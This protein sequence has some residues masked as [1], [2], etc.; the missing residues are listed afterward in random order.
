MSSF[1]D[2]KISTPLRNALDDLGLENP[3]P[4]Q[5][6]AFPVVMS[7]KDVVGIAQTGTGKTFAYLLPILNSLPFSKEKHPRVLIMVPTRELVV[8]VVEETEK[9][10]KYASIR[11]LGVYGG[12]NM[13]RQKEALAEGSDIVVA[14]P[15][16]LYDLVLARALQLKAV[17]KL[18]ID[19]VDVMLDLGFRFQLT[20]IFELLP[21]HR[22]NIMF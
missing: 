16:R 10:G 9:L 7:G 2:F 17:K 15:A 14:T 21:T 19:E 22:Q 8:Q 6:Q 11:V 1:T 5:E 18:V 3:T 20:N 4:V 12:T 13:K